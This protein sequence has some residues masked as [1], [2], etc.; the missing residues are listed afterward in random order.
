MNIRLFAYFFS[1]TFASMAAGI[2]DQMTPAAW[3][4]LLIM[5]FAAGFAS[6]VAYLDRSS[7]QPPS[8]S[9]LGKIVAT[10]AILAAIFL[11]TSCAA[12]D[13]S[14]RLTDGTKIRVGTHGAGASIELTREF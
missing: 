10:I 8:I 12:F 14:T 4:R 3:I 5:S 9:T 2:S 1:T 13:V 7:G 6:V 11:F